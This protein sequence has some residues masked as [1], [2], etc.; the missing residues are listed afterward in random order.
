[1]QNIKIENTLTNKWI[2]RLLQTVILISFF[3]QIEEVEAVFRPLMYGSWILLFVF[4]IVYRKGKL[5]LS[6]FT[7]IFIVSFMFFFSYCVICSMFGTAHLQ[8]GYLRTLLVPLLVVI[9]ADELSP[10]F[11]ENNLILVLKTYILSATALA[12]WIHIHFFFSFSAWIDAQSYLFAQ[13]N[14]AA[15]IWGSAILLIAFFIRP[16]SK[17]GKVFWIVIGAY[18]LYVLG[19]SQCRTAILALVISVVLYFLF[20]G[21]YKIIWAGVLVALIIVAVRVPI[22]HQFV[23]KALMLNRYE[24]ADIDRF[25]SGRITLY[26]EAFQAFKRSPVIGQGDWYVDNSYL[27]ILTGSGIIGFILIEIIWV[28]RAIGNFFGKAIDK[29]SHVFLIFI[30]IFYLVESFLEGYPP[31]GPGVASFMFWM[32]SIVLTRSENKLILKQQNI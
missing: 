3:S 29:R 7:V 19:L 12:I 15:Q 8:S 24:D 13:K 21:K 16:K 4:S 6:K 32:L 23:E 17:I 27:M 14:S 30:T 9:T 11:D 28:R 22:V 18:L 20:V 10:A 2:I 31:F 26:K 5:Q 1:M 25:S